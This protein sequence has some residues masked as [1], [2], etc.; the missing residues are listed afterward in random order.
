MGAVSKSSRLWLLAM[1]AGTAAVGAA[2]QAQDAPESES[3]TVTGERMPDPAQMTKGPEVEGIISA[4]SDGSMQVT[5]ADGTNT[6]IAIGDNTRI[7]ASGGFLGLS[8][9]K[10]A[11]NSLLNGLPVS[12]ETLQ[13]DGGLV[14]SEIELKNKDL[15]TASMIRTGTDQRFAEQTAATEALRG[16]VGDIDQYNVKGTTNVNFDTGKAVLSPQAK[17]DLCNAATQAEGMDNALLLVV[18]YTDS[19]GSQELNQ[20]LSEKRAGGVVNYLQ[21]ACGW[22]P[23]RMLTPTGMAEA[24]PAADNTTPEGMAQNRRVAVNILVSKGLDGL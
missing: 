7:K 21:Q 19:R 11:A 10:L 18:G 12:V 16:R 22:K 6:N 15:R 8:R 13:W 2:A 4:R 9:N 20:T 1:L 3:V 5:T 14:A 24:D 23:Y 17:A